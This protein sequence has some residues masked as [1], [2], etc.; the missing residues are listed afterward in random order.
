LIYQVYKPQTTM[1]QA[2]IYFSID[3]GSNLLLVKH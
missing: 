1:A 3:L 2:S